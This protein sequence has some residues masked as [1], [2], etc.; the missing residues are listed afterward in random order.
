MSLFTR[1]VC[2]YCEQCG[3]TTPTTTACL[4]KRLLEHAQIRQDGTAALRSDWHT[5]RIAT[6]KRSFESSLPTFESFD[7]ATPTRDSSEESSTTKRLCSSSPPNNRSS[8]FTASSPQS[9]DGD[10]P[11]PL[12]VEFTAAVPPAL[13][14]IG[15]LAILPPM[16]KIP[17][18]VQSHLPEFYESVT[19][20]FDFTTPHLGRQHFERWAGSLGNE[21]CNHLRRLKFRLPDASDEATFVGDGP[22]E[23]C[24]AVSRGAL[25]C[26]LERESAIEGGRQSVLPA[27]EKLLDRKL[28]KVDEGTPGSGFG[29][30][31][32]VAIGRAMAGSSVR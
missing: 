18:S 1:L 20:V 4:L 15:S 25:C 22:L 24:V 27:M 16:S 7:S 28:A 19:F 30:N 31:G 6:M 23:A 12:T 21:L 5:R 11:D 17:A 13:L 2:E 32:I 9:D 10:W 26:S 29:V 3:I 8:P 14:H